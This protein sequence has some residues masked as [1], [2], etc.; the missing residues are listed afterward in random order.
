MPSN[1]TGR[2]QRRSW[3]KPI[4]LSYKIPDNEGNFDVRKDFQRGN[5]IAPVEEI[6]EEDEV[7]DDQTGDGDGNGEDY[8]MEM[9]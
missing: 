6:P 7:E 9:D 4:N 5:N 8:A 2:K 3:T 1:L